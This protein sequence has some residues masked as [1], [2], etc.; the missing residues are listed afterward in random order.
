MRLFISPKGAEQRSI[1]GRLST[2]TDGAFQSKAK[3]KIYQLLAADK[4]EGIHHQW[5]LMH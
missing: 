3:K 1:F 4:T 5:P 2:K